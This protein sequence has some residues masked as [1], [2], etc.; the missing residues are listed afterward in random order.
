MTNVKVAAVYQE[1]TTRVLKNGDVVISDRKK[2]L[3][4]VVSRRR[5]LI[6]G[7]EGLVR[8]G[9]ATKLFL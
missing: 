9:T 2:G 1:Q 7:G 6:F 8:V 4:S 3:H 5:S